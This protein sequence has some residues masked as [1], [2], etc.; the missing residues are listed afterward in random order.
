M[1]YYCF[2]FYAL[3]LK[4]LLGSALGLVFTDF[5]FKFILLSIL[6]CFRFPICVCY[7]F[8]T[9]ERATPGE[10]VPSSILALADRS[11]LVGSVSV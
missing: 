11:L 8:V 6:L 7:G 10:E 3:N 2:A 9:V 4:L 5:V 1:Y